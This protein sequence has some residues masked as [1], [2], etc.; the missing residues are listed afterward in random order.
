MG[1]RR[2]SIIFAAMKDVPI[3]YRKEEFVRSME[4]RSI[5]A[6]MRDA[7]T[8]LFR[9]ECVRGTEQ[10][11]RNGLAVMRDVPIRQRKEEFVLVTVPR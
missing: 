5:F 4:R 10:S 1:R 3:R 8:L 11:K 9:E 7:T 6:V 2:G